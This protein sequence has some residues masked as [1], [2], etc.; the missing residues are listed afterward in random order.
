MRSRKILSSSKISL[1]LNFIM[2]YGVLT[3]NKNFKFYRTLNR[4]IQIFV[5]F[6]KSC[7]KLFIRNY[8]FW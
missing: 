2:Y 3:E 4:R 6:H 1:L 7:V 5:I 8:I